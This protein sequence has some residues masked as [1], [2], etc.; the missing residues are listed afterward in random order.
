MS[1]S[2]IIPVAKLSAFFRKRT[3]Q[4][5]AA[6]TWSILVLGG[7]YWVHKPVSPELALLSLV[8]LGDILAAGL[9][10]TLCGAIGRS[11]FKADTLSPLERF[12][13]QGAMG[14]GVLGLGWLLVGLFGGYSG[15]VAWLI[16]LLFLFLLRRAVWGWWAELNGFKELW[17]KTGRIEKI[18]ALGAAFMLLN[19]VLLALSPPTRWDALAY[20]L[21]LPQLYL[22]AGR[23]IF[24]P[25]NLFWGNPQLGE[26][27]FSFAMTLFHVETAALLNVFLGMV[28]LAGV[29]GFTTHRVALFSELNDLAAARSGWVAVIAILVGFSARYQMSWCYVD[30]LAAPMGLGMMICVFEWLQSRQ[31]GWLNWAGI[32][33]GLAVGVKYPSALLGMAVYGVI[34]LTVRPYRLTIPAVLKSGF[35]SLAVFTPWLIKNTLFTSNPFFP[36]FFTTPWASALRIQSASLNTNPPGSLLNNILFPFLAVVMGGENGLWYGAELGVIILWMGVVG[37]WIFWPKVEGKIIALALGLVWFFVIGVGAVLWQFQQTRIYFV[38]LPILGLLAGAGWSVLQSWSVQGIRLRRILGALLIFVVVLTCWQDSV[39]Q[40]STSPL[41]PAMGI[42]PSQTY[43]ENHLG[44]YALTMKSLLE[45][46]TGSRVLMLW[47]AARALCP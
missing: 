25:Y 10:L 32:F 16:L 41:Q 29:L 28:M 47:G 8:P 19:Q 13:A 33:L 45:L 31:S 12:G 30:I 4:L 7:Y 23:F 24:V 40:I 5:W 21:E 2:I 46:P 42:T 27:L 17:Q 35:L 34:A 18:L 36:Y 39:E 38:M 9:A 1:Q 43:L 3:V 26:M 20:H 37:L 14:S 15:W 22:K 44:W 11:L 6:V